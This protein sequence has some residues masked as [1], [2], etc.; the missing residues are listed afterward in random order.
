MSPKA[1]EVRDLALALP[2]NEK[3]ALAHE[4]LDSLPC[5]D[6]LLFDDEFIDELDRRKAEMLRDGST[7]EDWRAVLDEI[8]ASLPVE[9]EP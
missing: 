8:S 9:P 1:A 3:L 2:A 7:G 6:A 5:D 4:L